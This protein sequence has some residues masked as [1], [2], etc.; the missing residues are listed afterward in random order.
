MAI[1]PT[2]GKMSRQETLAA[3]RDFEKQASKH[4]RVEIYKQIALA[5]ISRVGHYDSEF[6]RQFA[7]SI[8]AKA[9]DF[10]V[11]KLKEKNEE[12]SEGFKQGGSEADKEASEEG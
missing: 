8:L 11:E 3:L 7:E 6:V 4:E 5:M 9:H 2:T 10:G 1:R 12:S